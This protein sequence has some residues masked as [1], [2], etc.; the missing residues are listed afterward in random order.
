MSLDLSPITESRLG[1]EA[2]KLGISVDA[3]VQQLMKDRVRRTE[4]RAAKFLRS[5]PGV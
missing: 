3:L 4:P 5:Q 1:E 2:R